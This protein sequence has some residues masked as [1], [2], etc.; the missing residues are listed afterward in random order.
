MSAKPFSYSWSRL[1]NYETCPKKYYEV[2]VCKHYVE[3]TTELAWG[4]RVHDAFKVALTSGAPLPAEFPYQKWA[5]SCLKWRS[6]G[7]TLLVEQKYALTRDLQAS[8]YFGPA[9]WYRGIGDAV[10][11]APPVALVLDWKTGK[12]KVDSKQLMLL[13][14]CVFAFYPD[15]HEV[16]SGF[17][18]LKHDASTTEIYKR[19]QMAD[20]WVGL[21]PRVAALEAATKNLEF[22][23]RPGPLCRR[24]C[25]VTSCPF[26]GK[27]TM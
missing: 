13:A 19:S 23:P 5:N 24:Y 9:V 2:D 3:D 16:E 4:N 26:H 27:G 10:G 7:G 25:P 11:I 18:W 17:V 8:P 20:E 6:A 15:V 12:P 1:K 14:A 21:L 22:P